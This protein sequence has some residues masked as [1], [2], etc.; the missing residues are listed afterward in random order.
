MKL[1]LK[2]HSCLVHW[3]CFQ[4][5]ENHESAAVSKHVT[6]VIIP[7]HFIIPAGSTVK[8]CLSQKP[9]ECLYVSFIRKYKTGSLANSNSEQIPTSNDTAELMHYCV[10]KP[11]RGVNLELWY[12]HKTLELD[13][14]KPVKNPL[15]LRA[16]ICYF[17]LD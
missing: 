3:Q 14:V 17:D 16:H 9:R 5:K 13:M 15:L 1:F 10:V 7:L 12:L 8:S 4:Q 6:S 11:K 2:E